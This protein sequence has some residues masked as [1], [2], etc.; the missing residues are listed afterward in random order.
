MAKYESIA[1]DILQ[2]IESGALKPGDKL[3]TVVELCE[4][5]GVS[6]ITVKRALEQLSEHG[7]VASRRGSGTYVKETTGFPSSM[8][9]SW[10]SDRAGGFTSEHAGRDE[11]S[12]VVYEFSICN[13]PAHVA[14][15][16]N[17]TEEDFAYYDER[18]R[19]SNGV[20]IVIEYTYMPIDVIPGMK[21]SQLY[22][23][24]YQYIK[25]TLGLKISSF[26]RTVRAVAATRQEAERLQCT[27]GS[28]LLELEQVGFLDSGVPFEYSVSRNVGDRFELHNVT[29]A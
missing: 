14:R 13:P 23:S 3:P 6:K 18:V 27:E 17:M 16:L 21:K 15:L 22:A 25:Q 26:H 10:Q 19:C 9:S 12:S 29:M 4:T 24:V 2:S 5:Y 7:L 20:P 28:P 1:A 11:V 8:L